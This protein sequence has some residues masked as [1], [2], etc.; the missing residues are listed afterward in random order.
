MYQA[1]IGKPNH[2]QDG[3]YQETTRCHHEWSSSSP[4]PASSRNF[5]GRIPAIRRRGNDLSNLCLTQQKT[6]DVEIQTDYRD[7]EAQTDPYSPEEIY[8]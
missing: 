5:A 3:L 2:M 8:R 4:I 6:K 7:G 1:H